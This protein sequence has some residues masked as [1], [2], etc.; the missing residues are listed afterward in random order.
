MLSISG[1]PITCEPHLRC[2]G[3]WLD[4]KLSW[5]VHIDRICQKALNRLHMIQRGVA[6]TWGF[7]PLI[8][9]RLVDAIILPSLFYAAP[10]WCSALRARSTR[11]APID[12]VLRL[13]GIG[14]MG[15]HR[16]VSGDAART[17]AGMTPAEFQLR[18]RVVD[19]YL[20]HLTYGEDLAATD[21][22]PHGTHIGP[23]EILQ[24]EL[25]GL[26]SRTATEQLTL[27]HFTRV[28]RRHFWYTDPSSPPWEPTLFAIGSRTSP[29]EAIQYI[30]EARDYSL[31]DELWV[32]TDGSVSGTLCGAATILFY[33]TNT[34]GQPSAVHFEG[35]H[36]S[37]QA[38][39]VALRLGCDR[40]VACPVPSR[41]TI[42][43]DSLTAL[44]AVLRRQG[45]STLAVAAR[46]A[47]H[48][49]CSHVPAL[50][51]WWT[52]SHVGLLENEMV[53][54]VAKEAAQPDT[55]Y[56]TI[57]TVP[58][59]RTCLR[60]AIQR[61]YSAQLQRQWECSSSESDLFQ[62]MPHFDSFISL[63][64]TYS[65][66]ETAL[67]AQF[68]T[69]HF[70]SGQYLHRFHHR[71]SPECVACGCT[72]DDRH[73][74]LFICPA[75]DIIRGRLTSKVRCHGHQWTWDYLTH[76]GRHYLAR[77]L[78]ATRSHPH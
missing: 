43:S 49:L 41:V 31:H 44:R 29:G 58:F 42:V 40:A 8:V 24:S 65:R 54:Q 7:H 25:R 55:T 53:D 39:L 2:L 13:C 75:F 15:L 69:G 62:A 17:V 12:R 63:T 71:D 4:S 56:P 34:V 36:S 26:S 28:E 3:V 23:I 45:G 37:T 76:D 6:T 5:E 21:S 74:R 47:L 1:I 22:T 46:R 14:I 72:L 32:F 35:L 16:T 61:H 20:R 66:Y 64:S 11:L 77:F 30:R 19:F 50:R 68:L 52:P 27:S 57:H 59:S 38:E 60:S 51:L 48:T 10:V 18:E 73:H 33:G 70:P 78:R 9:R 67:V